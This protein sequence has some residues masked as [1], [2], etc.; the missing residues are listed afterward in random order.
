MQYAL[1]THNICRIFSGTL[2]EVGFWQVNRVFSSKDLY[3]HNYFIRL[4][5]ILCI[6]VCMQN[7]LYTCKEQLLRPQNLLYLQQII[8]FI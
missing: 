8:W 2:V 7:I 1:K 4:Q 5:N 6:F 3:V